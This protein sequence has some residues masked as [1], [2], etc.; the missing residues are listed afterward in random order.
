[1]QAVQFQAQQKNIVLRTN[2]PM[3]LPQVQADL[4]KTSWVMINFLT[5]AIRYSPDTS[6]IDIAAYQKD[7]KVFFTVTDY[8]KGIDEKYLPA[9]LTG[10]SKC[11]VLMSAMVPA[12]DWRSPK[13]SLKHREGLHLGKKPYWEGSLFGFDL[14]Q[15]K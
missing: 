13:S 7:S 15:V 6:F 5:N 9:F 14:S 8:G 2:L 3:D 4:E 12:W 1:M 10:T 11:R